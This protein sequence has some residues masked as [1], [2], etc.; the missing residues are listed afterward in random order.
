MSGKF[1][2]AL[3]SDEVGDDHVLVLFDTQVDPVLY[4]LLAETGFFDDEHVG[5]VIYN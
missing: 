2:A 5:Y 1:Y 4:V 3:D